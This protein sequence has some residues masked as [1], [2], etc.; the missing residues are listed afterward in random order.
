MQGRSVLLDSWFV[1]FR[2]D[3]FGKERKRRAILIFYK[4]LLLPPSFFSSFLPLVC[5]VDRQ[6]RDG[7]AAQK[8]IFN[9][10]VFEPSH[11]DRKVID[12]LWQRWLAGR[13]GKCTAGSFKPPAFIRR[14]LE[15]PDSHSHFE[16]G[17]LM[18]L[19]CVQIAS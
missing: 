6:S 13:A 19:Q 10:K 8:E 2:S 9:K 18:G 11:V 1:R 17:S 7:T 3:V 16:N 12:C 14:C 5:P 4:G 15:N